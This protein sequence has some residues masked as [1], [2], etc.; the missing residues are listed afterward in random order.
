MLFVTTPVFLFTSLCSPQTRDHYQAGRYV[1]AQD[2][3]HDSRFFN[4]LGF[5]VGI[6]M[7]I[8]AWLAAL[9]SVGVFV[10]VV[11]IHAATASR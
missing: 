3:S 4:K 6:T 8:V 7:H 10:T 1:E 9:I 2:T 11:M 5:M